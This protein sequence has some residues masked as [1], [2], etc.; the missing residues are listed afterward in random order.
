MTQGQTKKETALPT[1]ADVAKTAGVSTATVSR[2]LNSPTQVSK[3]T[4][5]Q[6]MA[7]VDQLGYAPNYNARALAARQSKTI[8]AIIPTMENAI[9]ARG[10]QAFQERLRDHGYTLLVASSAYREDVEEEQI[11]TLAARGAD[12]L[13][14]IGYH[15]NEEIYEFLKKRKVPALIAWACDPSSNL[16][17]IGFNNRQ[18]MRALAEEVLDQGHTQVAF[19]SAPTA[20]NDR[21][22]GRVE[23]VKDA[24]LARGLDPSR[25]LL[26]ETH[27]SIEN[28]EQAC[29]EILTSGERPTA[30]M[31]G[32]DVLAIGALRAAVQLGLEVP[33]DISITG[34]DDIELAS[35]AL[36]PLTT[37]H[38]PH[39]RMGKQAADVLTNMLAGK[40][41]DRH[42]ELDT[43][44]T[45]RA[46]LG[47]APESAA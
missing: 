27:Y 26:A 38:V 41:F 30:I 42:T 35:V 8:G 32:N 44:V 31:C 5:D 9:F 4:L 24:M 20:T 28:G 47:P 39:R 15:R 6:V 22:R 14:L 12:A 33:K 3:T 13:L 19:I 10:L 1:L 18:A 17:A 21:A 36:L 29:R 34:F 37:V 16:P 11:R 25:L 23:A 43:E 45:H 40:S 46:T 7:A 2:C